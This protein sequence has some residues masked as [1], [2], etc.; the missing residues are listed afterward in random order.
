MKGPAFEKLRKCVEEYTDTDTSTVVGSIESFLRVTGVMIALVEAIAEA[1][2]P[3]PMLIKCP[4]C[5]ARH[6][7][8]GVWATKP[9]HTHSCQACGWTWRPT[10]EPTVGVR[11]LPG[12]K[13][14]ET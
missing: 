11:F 8:E 6:I 13:N 2:L 10:V 5:G 7:D 12:F 14:E 3:V 1:S 9:H 4:E